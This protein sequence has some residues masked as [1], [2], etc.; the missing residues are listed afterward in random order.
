MIPLL[1]VLDVVIHVDREGDVLL[2][3]HIHLG[4]F[5]ER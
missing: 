1:N 4:Q 5:S 2:E 3:A